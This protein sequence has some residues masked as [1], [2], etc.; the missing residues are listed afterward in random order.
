MELAAGA[1]RD[2]ETADRCLDPSNYTPYVSRI[3]TCLNGRPDQLDLKASDIV[4]FFFAFHI[5]HLTRSS[6]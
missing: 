4:R 3:R 2:Y 1:A 6:R 5:S